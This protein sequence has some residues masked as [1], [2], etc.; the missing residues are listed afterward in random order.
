MSRATTNRE[1]E[2]H[3]PSTCDLRS[4]VKI[5]SLKNSRGTG[6]LF[7][8]RF[9]FAIRSCFC[10]S[11]QED[12]PDEMMPNLVHMHLLS[13]LSLWML[14]LTHKTLCA[15]PTDTNQTAAFKSGAPT[16]EYWHCYADPTEAVY[17]AGLRDCQEL[18][19]DKRLPKR[20]IPGSQQIYSFCMQHL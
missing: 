16:Y 9:I 10:I 14:S 8:Q 17:L 3:C 20:S 1:H 15:G 18:L 13:I 4:H 7:P 5:P 2:A 12:R 11:V 19:V 6:R